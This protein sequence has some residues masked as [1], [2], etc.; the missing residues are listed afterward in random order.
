MDISLNT[1]FKVKN[2]ETGDFQFLKGYEKHIKIQLGA[3]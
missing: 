2:L 3:R 1:N